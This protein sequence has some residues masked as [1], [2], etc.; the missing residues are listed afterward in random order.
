MRRVLFALALAAMLTS[1]AGPP[2]QAA[3]HEYHTCPSEARGAVTHD[4]DASWVATSQSSR[5]IGTRV[6]PIGGV[7]ALVCIYQMFGGEYWIYK[8]PSP[9][10]VTCRAEAR[11]FYCGAT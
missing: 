9:E 6:A 7:V 10:Y 8:R 5:L 1:T 11:G 4:G 3:P 2:V